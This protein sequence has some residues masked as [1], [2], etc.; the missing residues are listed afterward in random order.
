MFLSTDE[1]AP[2]KISHMFVVNPQTGFYKLWSSSDS[3][4]VHHISHWFPL[5]LP[6]N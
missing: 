3:D 4:S 5:D 2:L 1:E 6:I